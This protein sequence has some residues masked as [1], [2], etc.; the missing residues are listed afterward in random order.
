MA[1]E[2]FKIYIKNARHKWARLF[3]QKSHDQ[4]FDTNTKIYFFS[5]YIQRHIFESNFAILN[6]ETQQKIF[7]I[8]SNVSRIINPH[9]PIAQKVVDE[10]VFRHFKSDLTDSSQIFDVHLF[11]N[12]NL[13]TSSFHLSVGFYIK[14][15]FKTDGFLANPNE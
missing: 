15:C 1:P 8:E 13:S 5:S 14:I 12:T 2:N 10:V 4:T 3:E 6:K 11:E 7:L 9:T